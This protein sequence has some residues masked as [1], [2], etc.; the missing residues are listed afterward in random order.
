MPKSQSVGSGLSCVGKT[1]AEST[2]A[3][4]ADTGSSSYPSHI[5]SSSNEAIRVADRRIRLSISSSCHA[6]PCTYGRVF[7]YGYAYSL[8][9]IAVRH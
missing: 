4:G 5:A 7:A 2:G 3:E 8:P 6:S 9:A 1:G